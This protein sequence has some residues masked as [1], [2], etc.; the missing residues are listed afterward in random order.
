M[1][2]TVVQE[3]KNKQLPQ[4]SGKIREYI[5][6]IMDILRTQ[7]VIWLERNGLKSVGRLN[8]NQLVDTIRQLRSL[9]Q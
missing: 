9:Y 5:E 1:L 8:K 6:L 3:R 7:K 2:N 4:F